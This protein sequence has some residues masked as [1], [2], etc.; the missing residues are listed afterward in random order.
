MTPLNHLSHVSYL[1]ISE[2][3]SPLGGIVCGIAWHQQGALSAAHALAMERVFGWSV[4]AGAGVKDGSLSVVL[5][6]NL[7]H[8]SPVASRNREEDLAHRE[9]LGKVLNTYML[10]S[11]YCCFN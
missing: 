7:I 2:C 5:Q 10:D 3:E 4:D 1:K 8:H 9:A 11:V 6:H